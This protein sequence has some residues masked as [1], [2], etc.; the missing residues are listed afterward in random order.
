MAELTR[1]DDVLDPPGGPRPERRPEPPRWA[2]LPFRI[3]PALI[4]L[5]LLGLLADI[6]LSIADRLTDPEPRVVV[7]YVDDRHC[8]DAT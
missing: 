2:S 3:I 7:C 5:V 4:V 8:R 6:A 1:D